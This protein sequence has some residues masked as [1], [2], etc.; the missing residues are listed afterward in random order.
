MSGGRGGVEVRS[1]EPSPPN[2]GAWSYPPNDEKWAFQD[3][4]GPSSSDAQACPW[5][6]ATV[7]DG[8]RGVQK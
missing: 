5:T 7:H 8:T 2:D 1:V 6:R 3:G 4:S